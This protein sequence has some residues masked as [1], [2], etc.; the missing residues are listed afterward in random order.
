MSFPR[1]T[2][3]LL[4]PSSLP[5]RG[6]IGDL[7]PAAY[8]F[9]NFL[10]SARQGLWQ[11]LPLSPLGLGNSPYSSLSAFAGNAM[12][13]S[14]ER[15][16]ERGWLPWDRL[17]DQAQPTGA[18]DYEEVRTRKLPFIEEAARNFLKNA[19][20]HARERFER[21]RTENAWWLE[22]FIVFRALRE[23]YNKD[24][25]NSWPRELAR[26]EPAAIKKA[27]R[28][29]KSDLASDRV[30]QFFFFE[31]WHAL[32]RYAAER[33]IRMAGDIAIFLNYDSADVWANPHL[34]QLDGDLNPTAVS[35]V[36]PDYFS[37]TGQRW[38]NPL[39][40]WDV[41]R[42]DG[43]DWWIKRLRW[44]AESVDYI[45]L[46]HFRGFEQYWEIPA[47]E[48]T[49]V[50]GRWVDGPKDDFFLKVREA[51]PSFPFF[52]EDLGVI[53]REVNALRERLHLPRMAV[54][55]FGF[56]DAGS[57][58]YLPHRC[59]P[60]SVIYTGTHDTD[61]A[62]GWWQTLGDYE[63]RNAEAYLGPCPD[64]IHWGLIR[65][66]VNSMSSLA[67]IPMQD[68]LGLGSDARMNRPSV[69]S[70]NWAWRLTP[71][72]TNDDLTQRLAHLAEVTDRLPEQ[73]RLGPAEEFAA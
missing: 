29:L 48:P 38:G 10:A 33:G 54:L 15:L 69:P 23:R 43:Y 27:T 52:A 67:V 32:R 71:R 41:M 72:A 47:H 34:F 53:T 21:F 50:N 1:A 20:G 18:V 64:G 68:V 56:G 11:V 62:V 39:Y 49:A 25:W 36:P 7:G 16:A 12:L 37:V 63:R 5:S 30:M 2:G 28:E 46:D 66:A 65:S 8:G 17:R 51:I 70:G 61:T 31:Q 55:Q 42:Q 73:I 4:H 57:H 26:R 59:M 24:A 40:R 44:T 45:R 35:G 14:L 22:G 58:I 9:V 6:G 3:I 19:S 60:D 13:I